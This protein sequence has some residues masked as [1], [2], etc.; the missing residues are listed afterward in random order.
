MGDK[1]RKFR[2]LPEASRRD[3]RTGAPKGGAALAA[4]PRPDEP[5]ALDS[6]RR[7]KSGSAA[8]MRIRGANA[9]PRRES[10]SAVAERIGGGSAIPR[11]AGV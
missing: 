11:R 6:H 8:R 1:F 5:P 2:I 10:A 7:R 9:H 4:G 3:N